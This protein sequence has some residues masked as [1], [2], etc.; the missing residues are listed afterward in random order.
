MLVVTACIAAIGGA[1]VHRWPLQWR[2]A[3]S[4][5]E[6]DQFADRLE[7]GFQMPKPTAVGL[8]VVRKAEMRR[9]LPCLWTDP[10][11]S[12]HA[13][14]VRCTPEQADWFNLGIGT[15]SIN[16]RWQFIRED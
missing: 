7:S 10:D 11:P 5:A 2:F 8:F 15:H 13:G 6:L 1:I 16:D 9:G 4:Q 14:F 12:G 3:I